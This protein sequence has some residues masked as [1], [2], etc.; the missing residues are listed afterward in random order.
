MIDKI[1]VF[2]GTMHCGEGDFQAC[3]RSVHAQK[4]VRVEHYVISHQREHEAHINLFN[5]WNSLQD[6]F[7]MFVKVDADTV[8][9]GDQVFTSVFKTMQ[10][11][12]ASSAQVRIH[13]HFTNS[14]ISGLNF[15][16][17]ESVFNVS[18]DVIYPD[19]CV[20]HKKLIH[21]DQGYFQNFDPIA[22]HCSQAT[23]IQAFHFGAHRGVKNR[24][25]ER[26]NIRR[27]DEAEPS[28]IRKYALA[29]FDASKNFKGVNGDF[30]YC[31]EFFLEQFRTAE[32]SLNG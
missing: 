5:T 10:E 20:T 26:E 9:K 18:N 17:K 12:Q 16:T 15:F 32:K 14:M 6:R 2:V 21:S 1:R 29:G 23:P 13:D 8:I 31:D 7:D 19:R 25:N 3:V 27:A 22:Y 30:D 4:N 11:N 28:V 24:F